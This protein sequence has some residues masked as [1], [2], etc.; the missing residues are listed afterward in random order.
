MNP[1]VA[2]VGGLESQGAKDESV[3]ICRDSLATPD[4]DPTGFPEG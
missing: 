4:L 1:C 3:I 2:T